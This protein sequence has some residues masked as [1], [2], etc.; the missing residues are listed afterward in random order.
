MVTYSKTFEENGSV[1]YVLHVF[2]LVKK[3]QSYLD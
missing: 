1:I 2:H 3:Y